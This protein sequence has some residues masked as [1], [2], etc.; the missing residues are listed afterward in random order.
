M[1]AGLFKDKVV[2]GANKVK[3]KSRVEFVNTEDLK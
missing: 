3:I 2:S 1:K